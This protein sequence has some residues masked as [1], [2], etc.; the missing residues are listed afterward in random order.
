MDQEQQSRKRLEVLNKYLSDSRNKSYFVG[1]VTVVFFIVFMIL[2]VIPAFRAVLSQNEENQKIEEATNQ[3]NNKFQNLETLIDEYESSSNLIEYFEDIYPSGFDQERAIETVNTFATNNDVFIDTFNFTEV[4]RD[5]PP[6][7]SFGVSNQVD[8][9]QISLKVEG[10]INNLV[11][12]VED[13]ESSRQI[14]N[15]TGVN[16]ARK[17]DDQIELVG[18]DR[19]Y[20]LLIDFEYFYVNLNNATN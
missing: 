8:F 11:Q 6:S 18:I 1:L 4:D 9:V 2:G 20:T 13:L 16:L 19:E 3:L 12:F 15:V 14:F 7:R 10:R 17:T 5:E